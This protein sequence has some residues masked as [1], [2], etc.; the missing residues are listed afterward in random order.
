MFFDSFHSTY[1]YSYS[2]GVR[3][4][5]MLDLESCTI[6]VIWGGFMGTVPAPYVDAH[7]E[8]DVGFRNGGPLFLSEKQYSE[9]KKMFVVGK[10]WAFVSRN[11]DNNLNRFVFG[12]DVE[13]IR[14]DLSS[15]D[16][17]FP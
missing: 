14:G 15:D 10:L 8:N 3:P 17:I 13:E 16:E 1:F 4:L 11:A 7:G 6:K 2:G 12:D 5:V 9:I